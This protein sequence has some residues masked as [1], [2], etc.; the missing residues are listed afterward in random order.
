MHRELRQAHVNAMHAHL[1]VR[2]VAQSGAARHI[3]S[4]GER[5][6]GHACR[7]AYRKERG[8]RK[9]VGA[10]F[11]VRCLLDHHAAAKHG[12]VFRIG[13]F[14]SIRMQSMSV[15]AAHKHRFRNG[16]VIIFPREAK[17]GIHALKRIAQ[18]R[19]HS[20]LLGVRSNLFVVETAIHRYVA[21]VFR[22]QK[23]L[24]RNKGA[25]QIIEFGR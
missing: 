2:Q 20:A 10:V 13:H 8:T 12:T 5:L 15:I 4:V 19:G 18:H 14:G 23:S 1:S 11:L 6:H 3:A 9:R 25:R 22:S 16:A 21:V 17:R 24:K 7:L